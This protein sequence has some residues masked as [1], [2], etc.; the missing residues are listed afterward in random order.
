MSF[1]GAVKKLFC[2][3]GLICASGACSA[4]P[5]WV[6]GVQKDPITDEAT[7][8]A[9]TDGIFMICSVYEGRKR[10]SVALSLAGNPE[11][12]IER[13][14]G[15]VTTRFDDKPSVTSDEW[16]VFTEDGSYQLTVPRG[17]ETEW[18]RD[19]F[20]SSS[21]FVRTG[22]SLGLGGKGDSRIDLRGAKYM[23]VVSFADQCGV[24]LYEPP[25]V[26][27]AKQGVPQ[28]TL[29]ML[30]KMGPKSTVCRKEAFFHLGL[31]DEGD[32][33]EDKDVGFYDAVK[34]YIKQYPQYCATREQNGLESWCN[35]NLTEDKT[36]TRSDKTTSALLDTYSINLHFNK[37][38]DE[39][40]ERCGN[41]FINQ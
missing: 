7:H 12:R 23:D 24:Q 35:D 14:K 2:A 1:V 32:L 9:L 22:D 6:F 37:G 21:L 17:S 13:K 3:V 38:S 27:R 34:M 30:F 11:H 18:L 25:A 31:L 40:V 39:F 8:Y 10:V 29:N 15:T 5:A 19:V 41:I 20:T 4:E 26:R 16:T 36:S 33:H 28:D